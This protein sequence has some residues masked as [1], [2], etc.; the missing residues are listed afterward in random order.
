[1]FFSGASKRESL[2]GTRVPIED[3]FDM[4]GFLKGSLKCLVIVKVKNLDCFVFS[5]SF[6]CVVILCRRMV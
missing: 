3:S 5:F 2:W 6:V 1:M 4:N